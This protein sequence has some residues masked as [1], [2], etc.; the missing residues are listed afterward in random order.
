MIITDLKSFSIHVV[1]TIG[2][3]L[4][5]TQAAVMDHTSRTF[6]TVPKTL[7][8][9]L[10]FIGEKTTCFLL[11][12]MT[13]IGDFLTQLI[14]APVNV[15]RTVVLFLAQLLD[16]PFYM[17]DVFYCIPRSGKA[18]LVVVAVLCV[19]Y[20]KVNFLAIPRLALNLVKS[21]CRGILKFFSILRNYKSIYQHV[22]N[23]GSG[24]TGQSNDNDT[25]AL[26]VVCQ[27]ASVQ[28][29]S[30]PCKHVCLCYSCVKALVDIDNRCPLCRGAVTK[31]ERVYIP[32]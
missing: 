2:E 30:L 24:G 31:F 27:D 21:L 13:V 17:Y 6:S 19:I 20:W 1:L 10:M 12:M 26:C 28:F 5:H 11:A 8:Q 14:L 16:I 3:Q 29:I 7:C 18:G 23:Y 25:K 22:V 9:S 32:L 4:N 15:I